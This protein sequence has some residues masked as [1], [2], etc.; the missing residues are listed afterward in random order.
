MND[1]S[2]LPPN[3][4]SP[5]RGRSNSPPWVSIILKVALVLTVL[6]VIVGFAVPIYLK[7]GCVL[8]RDINLELA[9][10]IE[11][12][13]NSYYTDNQ[14]MPVPAGITV[15]KG[16]NRFFTDTPE[17]V[18]IINLLAGLPPKSPRSI[19]LTPREGKN[20]KGGAIYDSTRTR[21]VGLYDSWG[22]PFVIIVD[23]NYEEKI[24]V[25]FKTPI[26]LNGRRAAVYSAGCDRVLETSDDVKT[27]SR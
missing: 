4:G 3:A 5:D 25:P 9:R 15:T 11:Q 19:Y 23:T 1:P 24:M 2:E 12:A 22:N 13:V 18:E 7:S 27:W 8:R 16:G 20:K 10:Q 21:I 26:T 17:G 14:T 6:L